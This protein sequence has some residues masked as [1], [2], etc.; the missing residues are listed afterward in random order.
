MTGAL[1]TYLKGR[2]VDVDHT[3]VRAMVPVDLRPPER[4]GQL[5]NEFG[6]VLLD[7]QLG[8]TFGSFIEDGGVSWLTFGRQTMLVPVGVIV[9]GLVSP[10]DDRL[11]AVAAILSLSAGS[12]Q[13]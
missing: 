4:I 7:E 1:R 5:G 10:G 3:T 11:L 6:L 12:R 2:G 13:S 8:R 9:G